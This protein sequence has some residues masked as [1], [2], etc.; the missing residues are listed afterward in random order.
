MPKKEVSK[1][2][3]VL[4]VDN[5]SSSAVFLKKNNLKIRT[6]IMGGSFNPFHLAHLNS[7]LT[8]REQFHLQNILL[9]P[10]FQT[11]LKKAEEEVSPFHRLEMLKGILSSY[12]FMKVDDQ[13][14]LRKGL[15]YTYQTITQLTKK[16]ANEDLFFIMGLDQFYIFDQW[17]NFKEILKKSKLIV[18]SRPGLSFPKKLLDCPKGL[19]PL[20]KSQRGKEISL[21]D[22]DNR[23]YFCSL[24]DMD[25]SSSYV[26]ERLREGKEVSQLLPE[27]VDSYIKQKQLYASQPE[28]LVV[29]VQELLDFSIKELKKKKAYDIKSFDLRSRP[30]P[31]SYGLIVSGSNTRQTKALAVHIKKS[32]KKHF[33]LKPLSEEGKESAR[34]IV[35]DYG[36][37]LIHIFYDYTKKF[38]KLEE[39]WTSPLSDSSSMAVRN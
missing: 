12:P 28:S 23:I 36:D 22:T 10:S 32:I 27:S 30:L 19:R 1:V 16:R 2:R 4:S 14:I 7:L 18:T 37:L 29:P 11:T 13:E 35:F 38:Y 21:K 8:V 34:W 24:K 15:S 25:I 6:G 20:I 33:G 9:I 31:F 3:T 5:I 39:L 17:K 26:R